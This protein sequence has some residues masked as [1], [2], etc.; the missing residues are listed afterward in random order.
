MLLAPRTTSLTTTSRQISSHSHPTL[1]PT[2]T[3]DSLPFK[4]PTRL[5]T[6]SNDSTKLTSSHSL[7][8]TSSTTADSTPFSRSTPLQVTTSHTRHT[9]VGPSDDTTTQLVPTPRT[10]NT[11]DTLSSILGKCKEH[12]SESTQLHS[13]KK[14]KWAREWEYHTYHNDSFSPTTSP[15]TTFGYT[16]NLSITPPTE[17]TISTKPTASNKSGESTSP[18]DGTPICTTSPLADIHT[19][20]PWPKNIMEIIKSILATDTPQPS[21]PD[22]VFELTREA[23][24]KNFC[25]LL[26]HK[27]SLA[28]AIDSQRNSPVGYGSEFRPIDTLEPLLFLHPYW[29]KVKSL[30]THGS[31][32][33]LQDTRGF[34]ATLRSI[35]AYVRR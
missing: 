26:R 17:I 14:V 4:L 24:L 34:Q 3:A 31:I 32:W 2:S 22:F 8:T 15:P 27:G 1:S 28:N 18:P 7:T 21:S 5:H 13:A 11:N 23:A 25:I 6:T 9:T 33:P 12:R 16:T 10:Q 20:V 29:S 30:L 35:L 19:H